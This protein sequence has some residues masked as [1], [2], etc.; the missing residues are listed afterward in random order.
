M[1]N[2]LGNYVSMLNSLANPL[3]YAL[4][5]PDF[6]KY[7]LLVPDWIKKAFK[8]SEEVAVKNFTGQY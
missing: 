5:Y 1:S 4:W 7:A 8:K 3:L 2:I 6:R